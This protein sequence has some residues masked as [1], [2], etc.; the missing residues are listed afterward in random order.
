MAIT[1]NKPTFVGKES[2]YMQQALQN[3][4]ISGDGPFTKKVHTLL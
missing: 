4:H 2:E 3:D 1:F